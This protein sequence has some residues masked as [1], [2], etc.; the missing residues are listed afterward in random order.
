MGHSICTWD[1]TILISSNLKWTTIRKQLVFIELFKSNALS[2]LKYL[3]F[4]CGTNTLHHII[5]LQGTAGSVFLA[6]T[7][8]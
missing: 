4:K 6:A 7:M 3:E 1:Y 5:W 8:T 2:D